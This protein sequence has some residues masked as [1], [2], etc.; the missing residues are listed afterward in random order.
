V[1][2]CDFRPVAGPTASTHRRVKSRDPLADLIALR[3]SVSVIP[4]PM[5]PTGG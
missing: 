4:S 3:K 2:W 1:Y 5:P